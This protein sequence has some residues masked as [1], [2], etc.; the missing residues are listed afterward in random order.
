MGQNNRQR[1]F[2][3]TV[4]GKVS[5][6]QLMASNV[7]DRA[8]C[9]SYAVAE[10]DDEEYGQDNSIVLSP[11]LVSSSSL[12]EHTATPEPIERGKKDKYLFLDASRS[13]VTK[14][15]FRRKT[16][17][18][19]WC[20]GNT[21]TTASVQSKSQGSL[22]SIPSVTTCSTIAWSEFE[23]EDAMPATQRENPSLSCKTF[24][25]KKSNHVRRWSGVDKDIREASVP[26][27]DVY[28]DVMVIRKVQS[29]LL[30]ELPY[31]S[32]TEGYEC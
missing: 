16:S 6:W 14:P 31:L 20:S 18:Q 29:E 3:E 17:G 5:A 8:C 9:F 19:S 27:A 4:P 28:H 11:S 21:A 7:I 15:V 22:A 24:K 32:R 2:G 12:S 30:A 26:S 13:V 25:S 23:E 1:F 10:F